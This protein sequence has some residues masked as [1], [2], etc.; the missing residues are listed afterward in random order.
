VRG[1]GACKTGPSHATAG[2]ATTANHRAFC[3]KQDSGSAAQWIHGGSDNVCAFLALLFVRMGVEL[4]ASPSPLSQAPVA[5]LA[6]PAHSRGGIQATT[7]GKGMAEDS[8]TSGEGNQAV[9]AEMPYQGAGYHDVFVSYASQDAVIAN[10]VVLAL[11]RS[12]LTCWIA[13]RDVVPGSLYAD[14]IVGA[15]NDAK[16]VVLV[17]SQHSVASPHVGKEIERASSKRRRIIAFHT[18]SAPLTRGFEYFLSESQWIDVATGGTDAAIGKLVEAVR[19]HVDPAAAMEA[20]VRPDSPAAAATRKVPGAGWVL[21]GGVAVV[22]LAIAYFVV[23]KFGLSKRIAEEKSIAAAMPAAV[24]AP[25]AI[26]EKSVAVL[27]FVDMS[28]KKDQEYFSDGLS[29]ELIDLLTRVPDLRVPA[30]TSSFYFKGKQTKISDIAKELGVAHVLEGSVRKSGN[31]LRVTAQLIRVDN[32]YHEW[33]ETYDRNLDDIF[34]I[35]DEIADAVVKALKV[36]L[37]EG[38]GRRP[39]PTTNTAAYTL[40]LQARSLWFKGGEQVDDQ[41]AIDYLRRAVTLDSAFARAWATLAIYMVN[42]AAFFGTRLEQHQ[43]TEAKEAA[44]RALQLDATLSDGHLAMAVVR[45]FVDWDWSGTDTELKRALEFDVANSYAVYVQSGLAAALGHIDQNV[46][47]TQRA[48]ALDP[49][50]A[51]NYASLGEAY[52]WAGRLIDAE[53]A[54]RKALELNDA[55]AGLHVTLANALLAKGEASAAYAEVQKERVSAIRQ[56]AL[57]R[58]LD[59][60]GRTREADQSLAIAERENSATQAFWIAVIYAGRN[61]VNRAFTWLDRAY[62]QRDPILVTNLKSDPLL[63]NLRSDP[64]YRALLQKMN[65]PP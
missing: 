18:D 17:L 27:P 25:P 8:P 64:R 61:D 50:Y 42:D 19:R 26:P 4:Y 22:V 11:E 52:R 20:R 56:V 39:I 3:A 47:L 53:A 12:G 37:L 30:R 24:P 55:G 35:Q 14:E 57:P 1:G 59:A 65:L 51:W 32:G 41:R 43:V 45:F 34:K 48:V 29:E 44:A 63:Q 38:E 6:L 13:P 9:R 58:A 28:E 46:R 21:T 62:R 2:F 33:S 49:L 16:V 7:Q 5:A 36:S 23:D 31:M 60:L 15:I 54:D 10:A 40:Y